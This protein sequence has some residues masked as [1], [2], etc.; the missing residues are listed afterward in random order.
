MSA[1][2][3]FRCDKRE[4]AACD[5]MSDI[6]NISMR[7]M[8]M[9]VEQELWIRSVLDGEEDDVWDDM[10]EEYELWPADT[11]LHPLDYPAFD[12]PVAMVE[13]AYAAFGGTENSFIMIWDGDRFVEPPGAP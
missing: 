2:Q 11:T 13:H 5:D 10:Q 1:K 4:R 8:H 3:R 9:Q 6:D 7:E 12:D